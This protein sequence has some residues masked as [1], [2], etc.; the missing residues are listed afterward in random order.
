MLA[1]AKLAVTPVGNPLT[2]SATADLNPLAAVVNEIDVVLP[3]VTVTL[4]ALGA[5]ARLGA[6]TVSE[7]VEVRVSPPPV[8]VTVMV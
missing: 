4:L 7:I 8:P 5:S 1:G 2:V 6:T 3:G